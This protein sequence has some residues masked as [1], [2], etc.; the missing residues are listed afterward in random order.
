MA[1]YNLTNGYTI[2]ISQDENPRDPREDD[3]MSKMICF[4][5][6]YNLGDKHDYK[7]NYQNDLNE[8]EKELIK[9][10]K[11][12]VILPVYIYEH[13]GITLSTTPFS[14]RW[15]SGQIGFILVSR[16]TVLKEYKV[17]RITEKIREKVKKIML[18]ELESYDS[19]LQ[20]DVKRYTVQDQEGEEVD[21]CSGFIGM[22]DEAII[23]VAGYVIQK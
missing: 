17:K 19:Y 11:P 10:E 9:A 2:G 14:C 3:N 15:D 8:L 12:V 4:H 6:R 5:R 21:S 13:S 20:G 22:T 1:T 16:E 7:L 23:A 18:A